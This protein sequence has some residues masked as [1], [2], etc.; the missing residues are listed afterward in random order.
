MSGWNWHKSS[1]LKMIQCSAVL[2]SIV[3][4][5]SEEASSAR[6]L[7][8]AV[9][10]A[11]NVK[12]GGSHTRLPRYFVHAELIRRPTHHESSQRGGENLFSRMINYSAADE[13]IVRSEEMEKPGRGGHVGKG[14]EIRSCKCISVDTISY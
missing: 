5:S 1:L 11:R 6:A 7:R 12:G 8:H 14:R 3:Y 13:P 4:L 2:I 10:D 9:I